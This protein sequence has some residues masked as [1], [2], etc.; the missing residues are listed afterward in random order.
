MENPIKIDDLGGT[1]IFGNTHLIHGF[2]RVWISK[3]PGS[4]ASIACSFS[5]LALCQERKKQFFR[6]PQIHS[7]AW[8]PGGV[9]PDR[10]LLLRDFRYPQLQIAPFQASTKPRCEP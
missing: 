4:R 8:K 1:H 10:S 3:L 5:S 7:C 2:G 6:T 9:A